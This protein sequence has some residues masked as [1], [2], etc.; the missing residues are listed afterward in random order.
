[1]QESADIGGNSWHHPQPSSVQSLCRQGNKDAFTDR[2]CPVCLSLLLIRAR[3]G[4]GVILT[5]AI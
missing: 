5:V 1:V 2:L 4:I 3:Q